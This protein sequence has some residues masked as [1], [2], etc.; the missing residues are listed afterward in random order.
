M[1]SIKEH[2]QLLKVVFDGSKHLNHV[3]SSDE[4]KKMTMIESKYPL[5]RLPVCGHCEK[6]AYWHHGGQAYCPS[7]GTYT[8]QP[9]T[10]A[11]YLASGYDVDATGNTA[12]HV[13]AREQTK[14]A[15]IIPNYGE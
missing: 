5:S 9:I 13:L 7:C 2:N 3:L 12:R 11:N 6:L 15:L 1:A 4:I 8:R 10:Y 14:R